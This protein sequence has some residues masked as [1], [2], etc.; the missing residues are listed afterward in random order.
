MNPVELTGSSVVLREFR[1]QDLQN[2]LAVVGDNR[3]TQWLSFDARGEDQAADMLSGILTRA[4]QTPRQEYYLA[5][6][7]PHEGGLIGFARLALD[8]VQAGKV[9]YAI[10]FDH[11]GH[12]YATDA[13]RT[14]V[15]FGFRQ[16]GLHRISAA[17]GPDNASSAAVVRKLGFGEEGR[18]RHHV[19]TNGA[20]RDSVLFSVLAD[21]WAPHPPAYA[22]ARTRLSARSEP[23]SRTTA[24]S[25]TRET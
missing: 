7:L 10:G 18:I 3:V 13:V 14:L 20:W 16:L 22:S 11:W 8:G 23:Y 6:A 2:V 1:G 24:P 5:V 19:H 17:I 12:G 4:Q 9:G 15:D 25:A 21:E